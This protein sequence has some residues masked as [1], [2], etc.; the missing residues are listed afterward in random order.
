M[1]TRGASMWGPCHMAQNLHDDSLSEV[2]PTQIGHLALEIR[3]NMAA[4][5]YTRGRGCL[6]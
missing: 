4:G 1:P 3:R 2:D 6:K 5:P